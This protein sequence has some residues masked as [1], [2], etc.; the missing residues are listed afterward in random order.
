MKFKNKP[1][2]TLQ[3]LNDFNFYL[4]G[5]EKGLNMYKKRVDIPFS[6]N[7]FRRIINPNAKDGMVFTAT[8]SPELTEDLKSKEMLYIVGVN[9]DTSIVSDCILINK[10]TL[11][12]AMTFV[13]EC[14]SNHI[15]YGNY[16]M[17]VRNEKQ[18]I[19]LVKKIKNIVGI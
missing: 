13:R 4:V 7:P 18:N 17:Q 1:N 12:S 15:D 3:V 10:T 2:I 11:K 5:K 16:L 6:I 19:Q 14:Y 9:V 8:A